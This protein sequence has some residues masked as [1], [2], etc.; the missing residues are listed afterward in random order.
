MIRTQRTGPERVLMT[1]D[2][3]GGVWTYS[4]E[5]AGS[6]A[7]EGVQIILAS[8]GSLPRP[9]QIAEARAVTGLELYALE[10]RLPWMD[11]PWDEVAAAGDWLV[12]LARD[13]HPDVIHLSEPVFGA[14]TWPSPCV[15]VGHSCVLSWW[16]A[17]LGQPAPSEWEGYRGAMRAGFAGAD[18]VVAPSYWML[19]ALGRHYGVRRGRV[20]PNGRR[21]DRFLPA[22]K[23]AIVL[24]ATRVW[25]PAKNVVA[26]DRA[27]DGLAWPVYAAGDRCPPGQRDPIVPEHVHMLGRLTPEELAAW[28]SRAAVF[29]LPARYEPFGLSILEA[30]LAGSALVLGDIPS[31]RETWDGVAIFVSPDDHLTLRLALGAMIGDAGLRHTLAMRA[32]R[33]ALGLSARRMG[34]D[35]L[36]LYSDLLLASRRPSDAEVGTCAS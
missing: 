9:E 8:L 23:E 33:R 24:T 21:A 6:L 31:L 26:L 11:D 36:T 3:V 19:Q 32:H 17:V 10:C 4:L 2:T 22:R 29:A 18:A 13:T 7:A 1:T 20:I 14:L 34:L 25:D 16:E 27:A 5:L 35:Y 12:S 30:A 15:V 28:L